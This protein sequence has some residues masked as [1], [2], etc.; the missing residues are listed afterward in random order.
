MAS[1]SKRKRGASSVGRSLSDFWPPE[2]RNTTVSLE[3]STQTT[4]AAFTSHL[5]SE[6][7]HATEVPD[8]DVCHSE[9]TSTPTAPDTTNGEFSGPIANDQQPSMQQLYTD[10]GDVYATCSTT[11]DFC[12]AVSSLSPAQKY[13]LLKNHK[14]PK[15][16]QSFPTTFIGGCNRSFH[17]KWLHDHPRMVYSEVVDGIFCIACTLFCCAESK[18]KFVT[19]PFSTWNK[20]GE[21]MSAHKHLNYHQTACEKADLLIQHTEKPQTTISALVDNRRVANIQKN[22]AILKSIAAAVLFCGRQCI[23]LRGDS[24][25]LNESGN[26]GNFLAL[27]RLLS[28][29][30]Q[31]LKSHLETPAMRSATYMSPQT[32]NEMIEVIGQ[33]II[34]KGI[35]DEL[36][37][38]PFYSILADEV[39]SHNMEHLALC[40]RYVDSERNVREEFLA[41]LKLERITGR[42]IAESILRFLKENGIPAKNMRVQGYDGASNMASER[43]GVQGLIKQE[44]PLATYVHCNG[45]CL[46]LVISKSC[47]LPDVRNILDCLRSCSQYF[48]NSPKRS[49]ALEMIVTQNVP[50]AGKRK[51]LLDLCKTRWAERHNAYQHFYQ[52]YVFIVEAL[53]MIGYRYHL[54]KYGS[55]YA[56][57]DSSSCSDAQQILASIT[58]FKFVVIFLTVYQYLSHLSGIT[59]KLQKKAS[60]IVEAHSMVAEVIDTYKMERVNVEAGFS[61]I[62]NHSV[63]LATK[64]GTE[65]SMPR[66]ASRQQHRSNIQSVSPKEYYRLNIAIPFLDHVVMHLE[67]QFTSTTATAVSL[68]SL[69]PSILCTNDHADTN[70]DRIAEA[71]KDDLPSPELLQVELWR[72]K[73]KF[74]AKTPEER[75]SSPAAAIKVCDRDSYPNLFILLQIACTIPV[76]SCECERSASTIRRLNNYMR[77]SMGKDRLS[78]LALLHIH[79]D[80]PVDLDKVVDLYARLHPRR[81]EMDSILLS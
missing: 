47:A 46:N 59:V 58:T 24:E 76:T 42:N 50:D 11:E 54:D 78:N 21:K 77:A 28:V 33:Q 35:L 81:L 56:D 34:L 13:H 25:K 26:P 23:A 10:I 49:G 14:K 30:D 62:Y 29:H 17:P 7:P 61:Q 6:Q 68:L 73:S 53:E 75:P 57:W 36:N 16:T 18:G 32:Q 63:V 22:R 79:Y 20:Q 55:L 15:E 41:C 72:W 4:S 67:E 12:K 74:M 43:V 9:E 80:I 5:S 38:A 37:A 70:L 27:L 3:E 2:K 39:T 64:V 45:H 19:Q 51:P 60:D 40:A 71:Y 8:S 48:L 52:A 31:D 1:H 44:A 66:I 65:A 69:V